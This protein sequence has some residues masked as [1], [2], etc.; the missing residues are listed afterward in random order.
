MTQEAGG[1]H[2]RP[3]QDGAQGP[4]AAARLR[5]ILNEAPG[6]G[7]PAVTAAEPVAAKPGLQLTPNTGAPTLELVRGRTEQPAQVPVP[8]GSTEGADPWREWPPMIAQAKASAKNTAPR[9][10]VPRG[11]GGAQ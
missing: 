8:A 9:E 3:R 7:A 1:V 10:Q 4:A 5:A 6:A 11:G 2:A